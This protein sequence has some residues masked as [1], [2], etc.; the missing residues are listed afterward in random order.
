MTITALP[1]PPSRSDDPAGFS[2]KADAFLAALP[3]FV[4]EANATGSAADDAA[5]AAEASA[6]AAASSASSASNQRTLAE[7]AKTAAE[8]AQGIAEAARDDAQAAQAAVESAISSGPVLSVNGR[9]GI[10]TGLAEAA[11]LAAKQATLVSG[12]NIKTV[13]G[14]SLLGSGNLTVGGGVPLDVGANAIGSFVFGHNASGSTVAE[15]GT[16]AGSS[17]NA[18]TCSTSGS[19]SV[20]SPRTGTWRAMQGVPNTYLGIFQRI[21]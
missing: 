5:T 6:I 16:I 20:A 3:T 15:G 4:T 18:G 2:A 11:D 17:L 12:T 1:T 7:T 14:S 19:F 13:N 10:V 8:T 21:A 9:T